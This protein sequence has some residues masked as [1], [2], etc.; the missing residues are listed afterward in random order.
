MRDI[1]DDRIT[2]W[3]ARNIY[4]IEYDEDS[5]TVDE[6][7]TEVRREQVREERLEGAVPFD[8]FQEGWEEK[9]P[10]EEI[11]EHYG[12][13]SDAEAKGSVLRH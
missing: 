8:E 13:W 2:H 5:L 11:L 12:N 10:P 1:E 4:E 7:G 9:C 3:A 6:E